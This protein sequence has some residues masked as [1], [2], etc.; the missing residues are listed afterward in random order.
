LRVIAGTF[1]R[2]ALLLRGAGVGA[3]TAVI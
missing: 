2:T 3:G 1:E